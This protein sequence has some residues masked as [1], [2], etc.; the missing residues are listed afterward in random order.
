MRFLFLFLFLFPVM[1]F[2][3]YIPK[4][5]VGKSTDGNVI[6]SDKKDCELNYSAE[7]ISIH[8]TGNNEYNVVVENTQMKEDVESCTDEADCQSKHESK[9]CSTNKARPIMNL[10]TMESYCTWF[11]PEHIGID[12]AK[13]DAYDAAKNQSDAKKTAMAQVR[14]MREAG[15]SVIDL[16]ILRNS[17]KSFNPGQKKQVL[18]TYST[19]KALLEVGNLAEAK[20]EIQAA[21]PDGSLVTDDDKNALISE[22]DKHLQ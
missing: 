14:K 21:T 1:L 22:I 8:E 12:Q 13:K 4:S 11:R 17:Q 5:Y 2:A 16:M 19:I 7:C 18:Q 3:S 15:Q 20:S 9:K 6:Y 10:D